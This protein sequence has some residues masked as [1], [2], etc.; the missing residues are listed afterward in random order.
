MKSNTAWNSG[1]LTN[2]L[3][4]V[5]MLSVLFSGSGL[6]EISPQPVPG[7]TLA[8]IDI[9]IIDFKGDANRW[10][11]TARDLIPL[12]K[13]DSYA[14]QAVADTIAILSESRLF[15]K[16]EVPDPTTTPEGI[17]LVFLLTPFERIKDIRITGAFPIFKKEVMNV[18]TIYNG[19]AFSE[20]MLAEQKARIETLFKKEGFLD[21]KATVFAQKDEK[22]QNYIVRVN[23]EKGDFYRINSVV[24]PGNE[25][26]SDF[27]LKMRTNTWKSSILF[28]IA[29]RFT[30]KTFKE[31]VKNFLQ[32]YREKGFADVKV[33]G[34]TQK[35]EALKTMD[36]RFD[37][38][39]GPFY[40]IGFKGNR[41]FF[42]STLGKEMTLVKEGNKGNVALRKSTR[43]IKTKYALSGYMDA[44]IKID[45]SRSKEGKKTIQDVTVLIDE[46]LQY[47]V[48]N[49]I[50]KGNH[51]I[52]TKNIR[53]QILTRPPGILAEGGYALKTLEADLNAIRTLYLKEGYTRARVEK[54]I[55]TLDPLPR[56]E[57][58]IKLLEIEIVIDEGVQSRI[59]K[60]SFPGLLAMETGTAIETGTAMETI[61]LKP[62]EVYREYMVKSD[63]NALKKQISE[64]GY[65]HIQVKGSAAFN[66]DRSV[67]DLSYEVNQ[68]H[69]VSV[70]QILYTGNF[71]TKDTILNDVM[72]VSTGEPL[73]LTRLLESRRN[74]NDMNAIDSVRFRTLGLKEKFEQV[75]LVIEVEEK[76][77]YFFEIGTGYDTERHF[78]ANST[79]GDHNFLGKNLNIETS[80]E[81]SQ[82]GFKAS[83]S[84]TDP[85]FLSTR[86][87]STTKLAAEKREE[88]NKDFGIQTVS[89]SQ[90]FSRQ[91][92]LQNLTT[93]LGFKYEFREQYLT[94]ET[95]STPA[96][97]ERYDPRNIFVTSPSVIY[98]TTDSFVRPRK[99]I[100]SSAS[101]D[102]S[103][104]IDNTLDDYI[105]IRLDARYYYTLFDPLTLA[106]RARYGSIQP[107]G[108]NQSVPEDQLFFLGGTSTVRGFDENMLA[109]DNTG[110]AVGGQQ[111]I[112]GSIETRYD[113]GMN[114]EVTAFYDV[115][116]L[117]KT[118][119]NAGSEDF[120]SS[121]GLGLR[122]MTPIGPI[123]LLYGWKLDPL[124]GE[125]SGSLHFSM[126][127]TF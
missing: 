54:K 83:I 73:S 36:I 72:T 17:D 16:I 61:T 40:K 109:F 2:K 15:K 79:L 69:F 39:E 32:F 28:G 58:Q 7:E 33:T 101:A 71:R 76:K 43:N 4:V 115:G 38:Q 118:F 50:V 62:G 96:S 70:G 110:D 25:T 93:D 31:D 46:G 26:F 87:S 107:Y 9:R 14:I 45:S 5:L 99:G 91:F 42:D 35:N 95:A 1:S 106:V 75:D 117:K 114:V 90:N 44:R 49:I 77:P 53:K 24:I 41:R 47:L 56:K 81:L 86:I 55:K 78:Y 89:L 84:L 37:I 82:I 10:K 3:I 121:V 124:P 88:F 57:K 11:S 74:L 22:D 51:G 27:R 92:P 126:G 108:E 63:E 66:T 94:D 20:Q 119:G 30:E 13:G 23:I 48:S 85:R 19:D 21:P 18:M 112:L 68:G 29:N 67:V 80:A 65:P 116:R 100:F 8:K 64:M 104:G 52:N 34:Q 123:G 127:Y 6:A 97:T 120:R 60:V 113:V 12:K 59:G 122:Y 111:A 98:R 102:I 125:S 103:K 105:K